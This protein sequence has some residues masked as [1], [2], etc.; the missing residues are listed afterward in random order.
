M[1]ARE[2][3]NAAYTSFNARDLGG[4]L[5]LMHTDVDWP[6]GMEGGR[7]HGHAGVRDYWTRQWGM[8]DPHV[9]P[10]G[11]ATDDAGDT[12]VSVHQVVRDLEGKVLMDQM[13]THVY[14]LEDGLI[15]RMEI[16]SPEIRDSE[17]E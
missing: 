12:V 7:V 8:M 4:V 16:R 14:S 10:V 2:L 3:L 9:E 11:F 15:R 5:R 1:A 13:V 17:E 6:N